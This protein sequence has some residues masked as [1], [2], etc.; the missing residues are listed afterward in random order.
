MF[1]NAGLRVQALDKRQAETYG[2]RLVDLHSFQ[3]TVDD[4][5]NISNCDI[6]IYVGGE[7]DEWVEAALR[8]AVNKDM[9]VINL[10]DALGDRV[11]EEELV[12][13]MQGEAEEEGTE[14]DEE[15]KEYDEH[16]WLSLKNAA[17][18]TERIAGALTEADP[19]NAETYRATAQ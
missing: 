12:E 1:G 11:K 16:V 19:A 9:I 2:D 4:I 8:S 5:A 13:G 14:E 3:P 7:S 17:Y 15:E 18:L 6:F 10:L